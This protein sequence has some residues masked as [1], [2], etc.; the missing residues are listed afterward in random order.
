MKMLYMPGL[1]SITDETYDIAKSSKLVHLI[2]LAD[3]T[4]FDYKKFRTD[5]IMQYISNFDVLFGSSF[6]GYFAFYLSVISGKTAILVNPSLYLD[7]RIDN[8]KKQ[9]PAELSFID[10]KAL[11]SI[12]VKPSGEKCGDI[13]VLMNLDDDVINAAKVTET[14]EKFGANLY[15]YEKGGHESSNFQG[16]MLPT[17][18][19]ILNSI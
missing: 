9:F 16:D 4:V 3:C 8:L 13:H 1:A 6:G 10:A 17:I 11:K 5:S 12:R 2:R 15:L 19:M 18:K 7:E 14:A